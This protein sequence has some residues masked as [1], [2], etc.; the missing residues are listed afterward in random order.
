MQTQEQTSLVELIERGWPNMTI[1]PIALPDSLHIVVGFVG[2][3]SKTTDLIDKMTLFKQT[4]SH[5]YQHICAEINTVVQKLYDALHTNNHEKI[6][7][8]IRH[9]RLLLQELSHASG[10]HLETEQL[11]L[12]I[13]LAEQQGAAAKFSGAGGGDCGIAVCFNASQAHAVRNTWQQAG[14]ITIT[15]E[16]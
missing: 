4:C 11:Q 13:E 7:T 9:N 6:L 8:L 3:G 12:L 16:S 2:K 5:E 15:G 10:A 1:Q 14:I